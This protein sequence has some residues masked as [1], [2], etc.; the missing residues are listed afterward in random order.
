M[1]FIDRTTIIIGGSRSRLRS[2]E[3]AIDRVTLSQGG[4]VTR[5]R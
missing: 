5:V 2:I 4:S 3:Q 1:I